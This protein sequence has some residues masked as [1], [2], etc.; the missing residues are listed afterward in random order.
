VPGWRPGGCFRNG[1]GVVR[2][3]TKVTKSNTTKHTRT[4]TTMTKITIKPKQTGFKVV[5][6]DGMRS[7]ERRIGICYSNDDGDAY[8]SHVYKCIY[9]VIHLVYL[10]MVCHICVYI[11]MYTYAYLSVYVYIYIYIH[12]YYYYDY[13]FVCLFFD[14]I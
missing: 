13:Y 7:R 10:F 2:I 1:F 12:T 3:H 4:D 11:C 6:R 8:Y 5:N 14:G 9:I